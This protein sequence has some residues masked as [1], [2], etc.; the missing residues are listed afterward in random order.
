MHQIRLRCINY[1]EVYYKLNGYLY[2]GKTLYCYLNQVIKFIFTNREIKLKKYDLLK[3]IQKTK[4]YPLCD[5]FVQRKCWYKCGQSWENKQSWSK[6]KSAWKSPWNIK[7]KFMSCL[8]T[9]W[10]SIHIIKLILMVFSLYYGFVGKCSYS[11]VMRDKVFRGELSSWLQITSKW[12]PTVINSKV[13]EH[14]DRKKAQW[15]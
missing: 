6:G 8:L 12:L 15:Q 5:V 2:K 4:Q 1:W 3:A 11:Q 14:T 7:K 10:N 13:L 9:Q